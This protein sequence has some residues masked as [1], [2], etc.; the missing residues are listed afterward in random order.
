MAAELG[1]DVIAGAAQHGADGVGEVA[2]AGLRTGDRD[3]GVEG[4]LGRLDEGQARRR[5]RVA[6]DEADGRVG[7]NAVQGHGEVEGE[8]VAVGEGVVVRQTVEHGVVDRGADVVA[9]RPTAEGRCVVDVARLGSGGDDH[10]ARP[11]VDLEEVGADPTATGQ[12]LEDL[13]HQG[14][15]LPRPGDLAGVEDLDHPQ[16]W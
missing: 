10:A 2:D 1:V 6:H 3:R 7:D 8:Q 5:L 12:R 4:A 16:A 15:G 11:L 13:G 9:E 14:P